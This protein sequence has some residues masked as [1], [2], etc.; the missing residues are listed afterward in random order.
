MRKLSTHL[1]VWL[2]ATLVLSSAEL[3]AQLPGGNVVGQIRIARG[4]FP[5]ERIFVTLQTRGVT[6]HQVYTDNEGRFA[7]YNLPTN[8]YHVIIEHKEYF[9]IDQLVIVNPA[10]SANSYVT[11]NL[12][13][14]TESK[15]EGAAAA[16]AV[17]GANPYL[18]DLAEYTKRYPKS[19]VKEFEA[20]V[21]SEKGGKVEEAI[22]HYQKAISEAPDFYPARNNLGSTYLNQGNFEGAQK[23][24]EEVIRIN[25][26]DAAAYFNLGN[27]F[28][29][30]RRYDD[31]LRMVE[32]GLRKQPNSG[33]GHFLL[34]SVYGRLGR[35]HEA[36][37]A[38]HDAIQ[39]EPTLSKVH[40]ELV[41]LYLREKRTPEAI[42]ELKFFL[43][44]FPADAMALQ[45][46]QVLSRL[47]GAALPPAKPSQ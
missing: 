14:R 25:Q 20:A 41:N 27:V 46:R 36:E 17:T 28:L 30:T 39:F 34:G 37:R 5:S 2:I 11:I 3:Q 8:P 4:N 38:L 45:A 18:A 23:E 43:K 15:D 29:L 31:C 47:E 21:K 42:S 9:P 22:R 35:L 1:F 10:V 19:V 13:P 6:V 24:F 16:P 26:S 44:T 40:L 33:L 7:F 32:E 12:E